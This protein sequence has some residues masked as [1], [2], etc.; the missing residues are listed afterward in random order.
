M[1]PQGP[2]AALHPLR[3]PL[4]VGWWPPAPG[5]WL[6]AALVLA[7]LFVLGWALFRRYRASAYRRRALAQFSRLVDEYGQSGDSRRLLTETNALLKSVALV[8]FARRDVASCSGATW[9]NFL[10]SAL[11]EE[12]QFPPGF[13]AANYSKDAQDVDIQRLQR[14]ASAWIKKHEATP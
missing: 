1:N 14:A 5:W 12:E 11:P 8:A 13:A 3:E 4:P 9:L 6:L 10:N 2:L 7:A